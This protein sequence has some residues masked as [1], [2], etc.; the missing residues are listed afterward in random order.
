MEIILMTSRTSRVRQLKLNKWQAWI[1]LPGVLL[2][3]VLGLLMVFWLLLQL[4]P[5][6]RETI[7]LDMLDA[8]TVAEQRTGRQKDALD[9]LALRVGEMQARQN[10]LNLHQQALAK[11]YGLELPVAN[12]P[13]LPQGGPEVPLGKQMSSL[14]NQAADLQY[15][16]NKSAA[17]HRLLNDWLAMGKRMK[18]QLPG[19]MPLDIGAF[20][21]N[22]G[23]RSDPFTG[24]QA[25]HEGIDFAAPVGTPIHAAAAGTVVSASFHNA[26]GNLVEIDHGAGISSR[27]AHA[28]KL[29]V[30]QGDHVNAGDVIALVGSTGRS[31]GA[32]LHFE[33]RFKG[34]AENPSRFLPAAAG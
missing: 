14:S 11:Q 19:Q 17:D 18:Y 4:V 1:V 16:I 23:A 3:T 10:L 25:M 21:S 5:G 2:G 15:Q 28:S 33:V 12:L 26:Y 9:V 30:K 24:R 29:M 8:S 7:L 20:T 34:E 27:Y 32:H 22:F 6:L 13:P 31:T